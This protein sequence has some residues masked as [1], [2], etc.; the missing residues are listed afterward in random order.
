MEGTK[1]VKIREI[2][3]EAFLKGVSEAITSSPLHAGAGDKVQSDPT[4]SKQIEIP[5]LT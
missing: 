4:A 1:P 2:N 3:V 5:S